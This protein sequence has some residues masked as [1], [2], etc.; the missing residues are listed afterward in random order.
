MIIAITKNYFGYFAFYK[1]LKKL[2]KFYSYR[3]FK[4]LKLIWLNLKFHFSNLLPLLKPL[5]FLNTLF[6]S[7]AFKLFE[8]QSVDSFKKFNLS[9]ESYLLIIFAQVS[10]SSITY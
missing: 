8:L 10:Y 7:Y 5:L 9:F 6:K 4:D 2:K 1:N 3:H